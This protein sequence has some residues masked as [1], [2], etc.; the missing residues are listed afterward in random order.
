[1][2]QAIDRLCLWRT[3]TLAALLSESNLAASISSRVFSSSERLS[4]SIWFSEVSV[5]S[6]VRRWVRSFSREARACSDPRRLE[7]SG[8][9]GSEGRQ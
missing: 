2:N 7:Q 1:M 8:F 5:A 4:H 9:Q 3:S 6:F